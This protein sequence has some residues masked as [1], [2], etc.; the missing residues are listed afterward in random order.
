MEDISCVW[1][2]VNEFREVSEQCACG[3]YA[4][5]TLCTLKTTS[6]KAK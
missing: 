2:A 1:W 6:N 3:V 4:R 5:V